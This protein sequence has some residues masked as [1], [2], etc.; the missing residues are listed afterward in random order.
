VKGYLLHTKLG[1]AGFDLYA[2]TLAAAY[3]SLEQFIKLF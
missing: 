2:G 1:F 3:K